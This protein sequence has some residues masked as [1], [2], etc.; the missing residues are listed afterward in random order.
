NINLNIM[1]KNINMETNI[2]DIKE[3][4]PKLVNPELEPTII[5]SN[6]SV[7]YPSTSPEGIATIFHILIASG[8]KSSKRKAPIINNKRKK[9][10][11]ETN[12]Q[13]KYEVMTELETIVN[14]IN[15]DSDNEIDEENKVIAQ[16]TGNKKNDSLLSIELEERKIALLEHQVKARKEAAEAEAIELQNRQLKINLGLDI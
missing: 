7:E 9:S 6:V 10:R 15:S 2:F 11:Q 13:M 4:L 3:F 14:V 12:S 8:L 16:T 5:Y 1:A